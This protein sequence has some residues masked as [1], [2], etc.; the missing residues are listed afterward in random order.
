MER[1]T[2][3]DSVESGTT[4]RGATRILIERNTGTVRFWWC[5]YVRTGVCGGA[6]ELIWVRHG[7][8]V[9]ILSCG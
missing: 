8:V 6:A 2:R 5:H 9:A 1:E 7:G 4:A 3:F